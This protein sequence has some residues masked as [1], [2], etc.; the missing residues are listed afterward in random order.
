MTNQAEE[1]RELKRV[2]WKPD[3]QEAINPTPFPY[4]S[5]MTPKRL[6]EEEGS[7]NK[8][9]SQNATMTVRRRWEDM[10]LRTLEERSVKEAP[11][12]PT[13]KK[14]SSPKL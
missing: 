6:N 13:V 5:E 1:L 14:G 7:D 8:I 3:E 9:D 10:E 2:L 4:Q 11:I 12:Q